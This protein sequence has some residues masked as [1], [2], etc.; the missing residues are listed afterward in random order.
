MLQKA[1]Q[2]QL[3]ADIKNAGLPKKPQAKKRQT[4]SNNQV[5][6][7][8]KELREMR[9]ILRNKDREMREILRNK[10]REMREILRSKNQEIC[11]KDRALR[12]AERKS[13]TSS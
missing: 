5:V 11:N 4:S 6:H 7:L 1:C 12:L 13:R 10:D 9:E 8:Q 2:R 3:E